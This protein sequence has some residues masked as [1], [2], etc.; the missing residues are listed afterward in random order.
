M[1]AVLLLALFFYA[2]AVSAHVHDW[3]SVKNDDSKGGSCTLVCN[4]TGQLHVIHLAAGDCPP[5]LDVSANAAVTPRLPLED[6]PVPSV[7][8]QPQEDTSLEGLSL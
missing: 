6:Q 8:E 7:E 5:H 3:E 4:F 1:R 2:D